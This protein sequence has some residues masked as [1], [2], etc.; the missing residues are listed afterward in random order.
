MRSEKKFWGILL[1]TSAAFIVILTFSL[2]RIIYPIHVEQMKLRARE[3]VNH[4]Q[5]VLPYLTPV[6][7]Q[8]Y[9]EKILRTSDE[10]S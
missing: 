4:M 7:R 6:L 10:V 3:T 2:M 9:L 1:L 8:Q 5:F